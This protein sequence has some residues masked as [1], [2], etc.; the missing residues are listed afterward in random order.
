[1]PYDS[2]RLA[3]GF[4]AD[5]PFMIKTVGNT[6][7]R[8]KDVCIEINPKTAKQLGLAEGKTARL[9]TPEGEARVRVHLFEGIMDG[10]IALPRGLGHTAYDNFIG[11]KG[12]NYNELVGAVT[13]PVSGLNAVW[14][15]RAKLSKT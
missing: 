9:T 1:M 8:G 4:I 15:I 12:A 3:N 5:S 14:A 2:M 6:I 7:L 13:D 11:N 10:V